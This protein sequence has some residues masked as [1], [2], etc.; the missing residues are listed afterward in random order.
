MQAFSSTGATIEPDFLVRPHLQHSRHRRTARG[1]PGDYLITYMTIAAFET[2]YQTSTGTDV[3]NFF[4]RDLLFSPFQSAT[5]GA[6]LLPV[7]RHR[8]WL[9]QLP[10]KSAELRDPES[11]GFQVRW[12]SDTDCPISGRLYVGGITTAGISGV[13]PAADRRRRQGVD[14]ERWRLC[15]HVR[16]DAEAAGGELRGAGPL[17]L[18]AQPMAHGPH[19]WPW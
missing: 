9:E 4:F 13:Y 2:S 7:G 3:L 1:E 16:C 8:R 10:A 5:E 12:D 14:A 17:R 11:G 6:R 19:S 15:K 18:Q